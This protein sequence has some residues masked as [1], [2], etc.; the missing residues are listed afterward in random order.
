[1]VV[2]VD[3]SEDARTA[4]EWAVREATAHGVPLLLVHAW[5]LPAVTSYGTQ[6]AYPFEAIEKA[7]QE[8]LTAEADHLRE[9]APDLDIETRLEYGSPIEVLLGLPAEHD[10]VVVG[11]RGVG[12]VVGLLLGSVSQAVVTR[13]ACPVLVVP[14]AAGKHA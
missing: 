14:P 5:S 11:S 7:A 13:A 2:G 3:G 8:L 1:V 10:L 12:R 6:A 4:A 9:L